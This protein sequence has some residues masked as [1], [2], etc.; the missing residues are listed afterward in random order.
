MSEQQDPKSKYV[1]LAGWQEIKIICRH[2]ECMA[3]IKTY[4][5][6]STKNIMGRIAPAKKGKMGAHRAEKTD[7]SFLL[8]FRTYSLS[9][10]QGS[11]KGHL[12]QKFPWKALVNKIKWKHN[13]PHQWCNM[14]NRCLTK[15]LSVH[16]FLNSFFKFM[17]FQSMFEGWVENSKQQVTKNNEL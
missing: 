5:R 13:W 4:K 11:W 3:Q 12:N 6:G 7:F 9:A 15:N 14:K 8:S 1:Y 10:K 17:T 16:F 2:H